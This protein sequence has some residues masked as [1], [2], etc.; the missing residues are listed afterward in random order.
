MLDD[1]GGQLVGTL[2][3]HVV[4]IGHAE[5]VVGDVHGLGAALIVQKV[6]VE[7]LRHAVA[8]LGIAVADQ[9][10]ALCTH[11]SGGI[12]LAAGIEVIQLIRRFDAG[13]PGAV[14]KVVVLTVHIAHADEI[15]VRIPPGH[16]Q[17]ALVA[18]T[19]QADINVGQ[20]NH[21]RPY[22]LQ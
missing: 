12:D 8:G 9:L 20:M 10:H 22:Q 14:H 2:A 3:L 1:D 6:Q 13:Q 17:A 18:G 21:L 11:Q 4:R 5:A 16:G 7:E 15:L 19:G